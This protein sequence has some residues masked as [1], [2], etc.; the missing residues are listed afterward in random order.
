M[1]AKPDECATLPAS[2]Q[3]RVYRASTQPVVAQVRLEVRLAEERAVPG[4][5]VAERPDG[6]VIY[7]HPETVASNDDIAATWVVARGIQDFGVRVQ[8][9]PLAAERIRQATAA[10][11]GRPVA[12]LIDGKVAMAPTVRSP[13]GDSAEISGDFTQTEA[14]RIA[15]GIGIP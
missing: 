11:V 12:I 15:T 1:K 13:I 9:Q 5:L 8:F 6:R 3:A 4:L 7:L 10:H 2:T 14:E